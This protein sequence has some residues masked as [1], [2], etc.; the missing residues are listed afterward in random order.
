MTSVEDFARP[1]LQRDRGDAKYSREEPSA[2]PAS[3]A[4]AFRMETTPPD[5]APTGPWVGRGHP[6]R[7]SRVDPARRRSCGQASTVGPSRSA[8]RRLIRLNSRLPPAWCRRS[9][10]GR[11]GRRE[12]RRGEGRGRERRVLNCTTVVRL[13]GSVCGSVGRAAASDTRGPWFKSSHR[14]FFNKKN[15][16]LPIVNCIEKTKIKK[17][18]PG[19]AHF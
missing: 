14:R 9:V 3:P 7:K 19:M 12:H 18:R 2:I 5:V 6:L 15:I 13:Q 17:T 10:G 1:T 8:P 11:R 16:Y 4:P